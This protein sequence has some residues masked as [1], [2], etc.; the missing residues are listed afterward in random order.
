MPKSVQYQLYIKAS[1][2]YAKE[3]NNNLFKYKA[4]K[5]KEKYLIEQGRLNE[6][7]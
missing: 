1:L 2:T 5:K 4:I 6:S 3:K 7:Q